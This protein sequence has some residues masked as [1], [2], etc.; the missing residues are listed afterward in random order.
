MMIEKSVRRTAVTTIG[1]AIAQFKGIGPGFDL[2]L[3][4]I[5]SYSR[6]LLVVR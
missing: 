6:L 2:L 1:E 3:R 4:A 5:L